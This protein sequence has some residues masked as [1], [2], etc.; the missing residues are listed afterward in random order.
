MLLAEGCSTVSTLIKD[1]QGAYRFFD[2][3]LYLH[4][5][6][7]VRAKV[8]AGALPS[9]GAHYARHGQTEG[10]PGAPLLDDVFDENVYLAENPDVAEAVRLGH[11][12]SG[13]AHFIAYGHAEGRSGAPEVENPPEVRFPA[14]LPPPSLRKRVH[15]VAQAYSFERVGKAVAATLA[16]AAAGYLPRATR[17]PTVLDFGCGCARV[18]AYFKQTG[19]MDIVGCDVDPEAI[20]WCRATL[21]DIGTFRVNGALPPIDVPAATFDL[22]YSVS[23]MTHLPEEMQTAWL[24]ELARIAKP[25]ALLLVTTCGIDA[26]DLSAQDRQVF[27]AK[28]FAYC[29][30]RLTPGL[31]EFYRSAF[32]S[33]AY[34]RRTWARFLEIMEFRPRAINNDQDLVVCRKPW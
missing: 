16:E 11:F 22:I 26:V 24:T 21:G 1:A 20:A 34:I 28:G 29:G 7:D 27:G 9:G 8:R 18:L 4:L 2:E 33:E 30:G 10:R 15:G 12:A 19:D 23:V 25:G 5:N 32:H 17:P 14:S 31:P 3:M 13:R 6:P